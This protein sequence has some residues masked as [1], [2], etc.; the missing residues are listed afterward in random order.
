MGV[1][2]NPRWMTLTASLIAVLI[3][4]LNLTM[5]F[6]LGRSLLEG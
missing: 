6:N 1:F 4:T 3:V 5:L 2:T